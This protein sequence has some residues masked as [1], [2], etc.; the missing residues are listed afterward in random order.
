MKHTHLLLV[1]TLLL[2][3]GGLSLAQQATGTLRG[4]I[5]DGDVDAPLAGATVT[6]IETG[7]K[8]DSDASGA[9]ALPQIIAGTYT[10]SIG[11]EG[12]LKEVQAGIRIN[13]GAVRDLDV[14]LAGD[15]ADLDEYV[16]QDPLTGSA[17]TETAVLNLRLES[18]SLID[19]ISSELMSRAGASDAAA[20][21][22]F[23]AGATV[24]DGKSAV[25][26]G[27]PD[28]YVSSQLNG[29]RLP[30]A[31]E[32]KRAVELDQFPSA[33]IET[34]EV[35]KTFTPDQQGDASGGAVDLRMKRIPDGD[36]FIKFS[37]QVSFNSQVKWRDDFLGYK[38]GG[39]NFFGRDDG[40]RDQQLDL[41][42]ANW[43]GAVGSNPI[44]APTDYKWSV[45]AGASHTFD[46][47]LK[48]GGFGSFFYERDTSF[49]D[50]GIDD[51]L[52][53]ENPGDPMTP[54]KFQETG[55]DDFKTGLF[56][57]TRSQRSVQWG[58]LLSAGLEYEEQAI[59][60]TYLYTRTAEDRVT[61]AEDTRGKA[62]FFPG[63]DPNDPTTP[64]HESPDAA[65]Y[66]RLE[67]LDYTERTTQT[68]QISG[69]HVLP[70]EPFGFA[71][72]MVF[73]APEINWSAAFSSAGLYQPDKRQFGSLWTPGREIFPGFKLPALHRP[74]L[75]AANF[76]L[77]FVQR[78]W[79]RIEEDSEQYSLSIKL[80]FEQWTENEGF[81][82]FGYFSDSVTR[83]FNQDT[84]SNFGDAG[85]S[86]EAPFEQFWSRSFPSENHPIF[87]SLLDVDYEGELN[88]EALYAMVS[89]PLTSNLKLT[90]GLRFEWTEVGIVN[91][92]EAEATWFPPSSLAVTALNPGDADVA[93]E[94]ADR[95]PSIGLEYKPLDELIIRA[96]YNETV[97]RQTFKELS[98]ILQQEFLGGP[99]FIGNPD[100]QM[101]SVKNYDLRVDYIPYAGSLISA[102][103]FQKDL[104]NPIEYVQK[105]ATFNFTTA[106]N[107][108]EGSLTGFEFEVR[109]SLGHFV[110]D[111]EGLSVGA[112][113]TFINSEVRLPDDEFAALSLPNVLAAERTRDMTNAPEHLFNF[114][115]TYDV[116]DTGTQF[117]LFYTIRGDTLIAGSGEALG[118]YVPSIYQT[119]F[120]TLNFSA[121]Q[122][123]GETFRIQFQAKNL[124][125]EKNEEV[126]RSK[127]IGDDVLRR[128]NTSG[129]EFSLTL[130][131]EFRF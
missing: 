54:R 61:L 24:Q 109:Q 7:Q 55:A 114:Y 98:P 37:S 31:D 92:A 59:N 85:A 15:F 80:P 44:S 69:S 113:A 47:G 104:K 46:S 3:L 45:A 67:T 88:V 33:I 62:Y 95:L 58:T 110:D 8:A 121:S 14:V 75:P 25:I 22:T 28:R 105:L 43:L 125:N 94:Q 16:V 117:G 41:L 82:K 60:F 129:V 9:Y 63:H 73:G 65:P 100:L 91:D 78:I 11:K 103:W 13:A 115:L 106:V 81:F 10:V 101:S 90:G 76:N 68:F 48:I 51:S 23:I 124:T 19:A 1:L 89:L 18:P 57:V 102:S 4:Q 26:R 66:L 35:S 112:N 130:S 96:A 119:E 99:I 27:L 42:G 86:L 50:N 93:F 107:Y 36:P 30:T 21:M 122:Q 38:G 34:I 49:Y 12:Y 87:D 70:Y 39:V 64:G 74:F 84:F 40:D 131:G 118:N 53:V 56:D 108:P 17:G 128:S 71:D 79:K 97:A 116:P 127:F 2:A 77:G 72:T 32:N 5:K 29:L 20:A 83:T 120:G 123:L 126:Y 52:W 111:L 6:I